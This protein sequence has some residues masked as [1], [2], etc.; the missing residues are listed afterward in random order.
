[1]HKDRYE[2]VAGSRHG[3][4]ILWV[5][6]LPHG[7]M[8]ATKTS[9]CD[10]LKIK[11]LLSPAVENANGLSILPSSETQYLVLAYTASRMRVH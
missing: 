3:K 6:E 9:F 8:F 11:H 2:H 7:T 1:M 5:H 10:S 4:R